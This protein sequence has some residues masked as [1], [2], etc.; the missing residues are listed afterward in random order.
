M[1]IV[2]IWSDTAIDELREI[3]SY[4]VDKANKKVAD[5]LINAIVDQTIKLEKTPRV[6]QIEELLLHLEKEIRYIVQGNYKIVYWIDDKIITIATIFDC[7]QN[8]TKLGCKKI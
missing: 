7:R 5:K 6:G 1:E 4:Y 3:Y 8:P 2:V